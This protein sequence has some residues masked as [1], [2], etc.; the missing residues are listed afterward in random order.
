[1]FRGTKFRRNRQV[2]TEAQTDQYDPDSPPESSFISEFTGTLVTSVMVTPDTLSQLTPKQA[3]SIA[4]YWGDRTRGPLWFLEAH[5]IS[6]IRSD[7]E[8]F[9][10]SDIVGLT[11]K[12][13]KWIGKGGAPDL[14]AAAF[15]GVG[16]SA[17]YLRVGQS[18]SA[19]NRIFRFKESEVK[20]GKT[21]KKKFSLYP[22]QMFP[23]DYAYDGEVT[24]IDM[25][26]S[27][28]GSSGTNPAPQVS[29]DEATSI[30]RSTLAGKT[31]A[32]MFEAILE[33]SALKSVGTLFGVNLMEA[34]TD[35]SLT[36]ILIENNV[37]VV[38]ADGKFEVP[39]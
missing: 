12:D 15:R 26:K 23:A 6:V 9:R 11:S 20:M 13:G 31:P 19:V 4:K 28:S 30:L 39:A 10:G 14:L 16:A 27:D 33:N 25:S 35:D 38:N 2:T 36:K 18:D 21:Y 5:G 17:S 7:G 32:Q 22:M 34:A 24:I 3:D 29:S 1:M 8:P 37:L